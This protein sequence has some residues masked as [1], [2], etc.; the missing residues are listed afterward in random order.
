MSV[1]QARL[2]LLTIGIT[3]ASRFCLVRDHLRRRVSWDGLMETAG[4]GVSR[5]TISSGRSVLDAVLVRPESAQASVLICHGIGETV[6]LW[7]DVQQLLA[8]SGV[9]SLVFDY[10]GY[11]R[12][13]GFFTAS[14]AEQDAV[15]AFRCL[16][17]LTAPLPV[18][19]FGMSLGS[20]IAGAIIGE[21]PAHRLVLCGAF[22]SLRKA[23]VSVGI[24]KAFESGVPPIWDTAD[25]L[26][27]CRVP[28]LIV[29]G[30]KDRLFPVR[31]AR[32]LAASCTSPCELVIVPNISHA[33]PF[34]H[35]QPSYWGSIIAR[36]LVEDEA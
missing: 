9:A 27:S 14:Q 24:P 22:T 1:A 32:E 4:P 13:S 35:P 34:Y 28:T 20:G 36:F 31:M 11:G 16:E 15:A 26:R 30:E 3:I 8:A 2:L 23:A 18:A 5:H 6:E 17:Q 19:V 7:H 29:H 12:S 33:D 21:V 25:T 10:T